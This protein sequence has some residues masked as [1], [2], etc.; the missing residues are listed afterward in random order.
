MVDLIP[1]IGCIGINLKTERTI[2][3]IKKLFSKYDTLKNFS[4]SFF[5]KILYMNV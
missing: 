2:K 4:I 5:I 3:L 1:K